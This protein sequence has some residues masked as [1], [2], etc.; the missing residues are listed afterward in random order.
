MSGSVALDEQEVSAEEESLFEFQVI[1]D[2]NVFP[3]LLHFFFERR[4]MMDVK[5]VGLWIDY[6]EPR[7]ASVSSRLEEIFRVCTKSESTLTSIRKRLENIGNPSVVTR[8]VE[9]SKLLRRK[10][11]NIKR[12]SPAVIIGHYIGDR[13]IDVTNISKFKILLN[14]KLY[15]IRLASRKRKEKE[16]SAVASE[17]KARMD[18]L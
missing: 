12:H 14:K 8:L 16:L 17:Y 6:F 11:G 7:N 15:I 2:I 18:F 5:R 9:Y 4:T 13:L 10:Y 3:D 1:E